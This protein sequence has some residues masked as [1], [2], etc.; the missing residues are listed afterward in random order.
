[1]A[2]GDSA[3]L[4]QMDD[5]TLDGK[6]HEATDVYCRLVAAHP[7]SGRADHHARHDHGRAVPPRA[8][9][10]PAACPT[11]SSATST[12]TTRSWGSGPA[13]DCS[14]GSPSGSGT[15]PS[16]R[17]CT[18]CRRASTCGRSS[19]AASRATTRASR[20][21]ARRTCCRATSSSTATSRTRTPLVEGSVDERF[22]RMFHAIV[23]GD[24]VIA[25]SALPG[26]GRPSPSCATALRNEVLFAAIID[27]QEFNS[28]RR[29]RHIGHKAIR[30]RSMLD[31]ADWV[32]WDA[33]AP[34]L[35]HRGARPLQRAD[36]PL[37]LRSRELPARHHLQGQAVPAA[38][39][40]HRAADRGRAGR[41]DRR[42][43]WRATRSR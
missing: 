41:A 24:K 22:Q 2:T 23:D 5:Y 11:A 25:L 43:S 10:P 21:S 12:T 14:P 17:P 7:D 28:F 6:Y 16:R 18:T 13:C 20:R 30:T 4:Q 42:G 29:V 39:D 36:L 34:V 3:L 9:A 27:Q 26:A 19:S 31:V 1:M 35:L 37:A 40:Q 15:S 8:G 38:R 32:G 33:G